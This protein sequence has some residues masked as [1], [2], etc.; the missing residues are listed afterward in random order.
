MKILKKYSETFHYVDLIQ[1]SADTE[2]N[3]L[4]FLPPIAYQ[5][6]AAQEKL[7]VAVDVDDVYHGHLM[8]G[9]VY[10]HGKVLQIYCLP[11]FRGKGVTDKLMS[12]LVD[13]YTNNNFL[14]ISARVAADLGPANTFYERLGFITRSVVEGGKSK[15]RF[16]NKKVLELSTPSFFDLFGAEPDQFLPSIRYAD[17]IGSELP[18][19]AVDLNVFFDVG[20]RRLRKDEAGLVFSAAF[21]GDI[22]IVIADEF[23]NELQRTTNDPK[24]DL[25]LEFA[26]KFP[27]LPSPNERQT[28]R[29]FNTLAEVIFPDRF[30]AL[31]LSIQDKSDLKHLVCAIHNRVS[32]FITSEKTILRSH[33]FLMNEF[34]LDVLGVSDFSDA[35]SVGTGI[36]DPIIDATVEEKILSVVAIDRIDRKLI[37]GFLIRN[38]MS[39]D[40]V[41]RSESVSKFNDNSNHIAILED[42]D[43]VMI[44]TWSLKTR[45][46][47]NVDSMICADEDHVSV[48]TAIDYALNQMCKLTSEGAPTELNLRIPP[49]H[50]VTK[51]IALTHGFRRNMNA[52]KGQRELYKISYGKIIFT[53]EWPILCKWLRAVSGVKLQTKS[54]DCS[55]LDKL[56]EIKD[57]QG[58][59]YE[60]A[61]FDFETLLSPAIF[62]LAGRDA[63]IV[64]IRREHAD[65]LLGT[66]D[67]L[68]LL[69]VQEAALLKERAYFGTP[70][71]ASKLL[72]GTLIL[73]YESSRNGGRKC[74]VALARVTDSRVLGIDE[75]GTS[76]HRHGVLNGVGIDK[77]GKSKTKLVTHFDNIFKFTSPVSLKRMRELGGDD[78]TNFISATQI[79]HSQ[80]L[81]IVDEGKINV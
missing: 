15:G 50:P 58:V 70:R 45:P 25:Y 9:G 55:N 29:L 76:T 34:G 2:R 14:S 53:E 81:Q 33:D 16:I 20:K 46:R 71:A 44:A 38:G 3:A 62:L 79:D 21:N 10:P 41:P 73:F 11:E 77:I 18:V 42:N 19:Y 23:V 22:R 39:P 12:T 48:K 80:L 26:R 32:G 66:T 47:K 43:L 27:V 69:G 17:Q 13:H 74:I 52:N 8:F 24:D 36:L 1:R 6:A 59:K 4:G 37:D 72:P 64:P 60:M 68:Q 28:K 63:T 49:G 35:M 51:R 56:I 78:G 5:D 31:K 61:L 7:Y 57:A 40:V 30:R 65:N 75:I 67:Q 54:P